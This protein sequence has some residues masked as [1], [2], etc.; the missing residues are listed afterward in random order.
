VG[1]SRLGVKNGWFA[2]Q[3]FEARVTTWRSVEGS[4][5]SFPTFCIEREDAPICQPFLGF[6]Q[7]RFENE[8]AD[9]LTRLRNK[10]SMRLTRQIEFVIPACF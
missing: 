9:G 8:F 10:V 7:R 3:S 6:A 5:E 4:D 1:L 2:E